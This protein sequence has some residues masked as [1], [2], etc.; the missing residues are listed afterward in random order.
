MYA[1]ALFVFFSFTARCVFSYTRGVCST[2]RW[3]LMYCV[4]QLYTVRCVSVRLVYF[5]VQLYTVRC[6][7]VPLVYC[8]VQ[9]YT[10]RCVSVPLVYCVVC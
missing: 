2:I 1:R 9:L 10:V 8:V 5:V 4:V 6:V 3:V 7:S